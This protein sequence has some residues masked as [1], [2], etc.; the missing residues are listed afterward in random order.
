M[1]AV[2]AASW[3]TPDTIETF[4]SLGPTTDGRTK[5]DLVGAD[6]GDSVSYGALGFAGTSQ[7]SP[8]VAGLAA[9]VRQQ[10]PSFTP[11][12]VA[13][14]L[15]DNALPRGTEP[16]NTWG[17]GLAELPSLTPG[18]PTNVSATAGDGQATVTW[19]VPM[20]DGGTPVTQYVV[21]SAAVVVAVTSTVA[22][23]TVSGTV[24][25]LTNGTAYTFTVAAENSVGVGQSSSAS[26]AV[27]P[28]GSTRASDEPHGSGR[29]RP[30]HSQL[31]GAYIRRW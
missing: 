28:P 18:A 19:T 20:A 9:L 30:G 13:G 12:Q 14:Y 29:E 22:S 16:N 17:H 21:T 26:N 11:A 23:S 6:R 31:D 8:H 3:Q 27:T 4:S 24:T 5:P 25:G 7:A 1:I 10:F 2:G 15:K